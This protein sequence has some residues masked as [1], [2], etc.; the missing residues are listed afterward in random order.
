MFRAMLAQR[1]HFE[2]FQIR[3]ILRM[4]EVENILRRYRVFRTIPARSTL[5]EWKEEGLFEGIQING[6]HYVYEDSLESWLKRLQ[7][8]AAA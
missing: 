3:T 8:P 1:P 6:V 2:A 7:Q 5:I 4:S